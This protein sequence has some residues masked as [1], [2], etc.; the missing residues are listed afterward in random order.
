MFGSKADW[1]TNS[2]RGKP[3][4]WPTG[5]RGQ[6]AYGAAYEQYKT[7]NKIERGAPSGGNKLAMDVISSNLC[8][9]VDLY[10]YTARGS[11]KYFNKGKTMSLVHI[12]GLEHWMYRTAMEEGGVC[13]YS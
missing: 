7:E 8:S 1:Q 9:R 2:Y 10:G 11:A 12:L 13:V 5:S 3:L 4:I 6:E